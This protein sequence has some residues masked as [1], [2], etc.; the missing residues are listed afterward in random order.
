MR[1]HNSSLKHS[2]ADLWPRLREEA[3]A[4]VKNEP[5]L[6][7]FISDM[8]LQHDAFEQ[9]VV[10]RLGA[11]LDRSFF[12]ASQVRQL[13]DDVLARDPALPQAFRSDLLAV[14]ERDAACHRLIE[15][16]LYFKGF[17]ALQS[18]RLAHA[19]WK[20][21]REDFALLI[22]H[23][24]TVVMNVDI[25]PGAVI[26]SGIMLDH[27]TGFVCGETA[28]VEDNV[29][30]L[31]NVTLGGS[32]AVKGSDRHPKIRHGVLIGAGAKII[33]NVE[34]GAC[35]RVAASSVVLQDVPPGKTV[36]GVPARIVGEA[37]CKEP[38]RQMD[39]AFIC[40][41]QI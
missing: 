2:E 22:Q 37:G 39:Q 25:H 18:Y 9:A 3:E 15:P 6:S 19:L 12:P 16:F 8:I 17:G 40:D 34:I 10:Y 23:R 11:W 30:I 26:G 31:H 21:G 32:T 38:S 1:Q 35:S 36:A 4:V 29:S 7:K 14:L 5:L 20:Q 27:A 28:V 41:F 33:G 13:Y 24:M